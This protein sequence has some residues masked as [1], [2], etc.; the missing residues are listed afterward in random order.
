MLAQ[1]SRYLAQVPKEGRDLRRELAFYA[2]LMARVH[3]VKWNLLRLAWNL[4]R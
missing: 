1:V 2:V 4:L 3:G